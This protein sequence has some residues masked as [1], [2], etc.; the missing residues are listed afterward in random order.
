MNA[1][2]AQQG[3]TGAELGKGALIGTG[4][5]TAAGLATALLSKGKIKAGLGTKV[6]A[7]G[8]GVLGLYGG[9]VKGQ[10]DKR[11]TEIMRKYQ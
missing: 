9:A 7:L 3:H 4:A 5:G 1:Y 11:S 2:F 10:F 8:G 6:G